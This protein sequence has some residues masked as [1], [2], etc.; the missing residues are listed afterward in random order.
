MGIGKDSSLH[1][2]SGCK[3]AKMHDASQFSKTVH[4]GAES[5]VES[6]KGSQIMI[7]KHENAIIALSQT[8]KNMEQQIK[9]MARIM[10][11]Q[12]I[13]KLNEN[14]KTG[15]EELRR[16]MHHDVQMKLNDLRSNM[17]KELADLASR[18]NNIVKRID[19]VEDKMTNRLH[20]R[21]D[22][23]QRQRTE[24]DEKVDKVEADLKTQTQQLTAQIVKSQAT[25]D[26][27]CN[28]IKKLFRELEESNEET[29]KQQ[30]NMLLHLETEARKH[31]ELS[32]EQ[33]AD[34]GVRLQKAVSRAVTNFEDKM[35]ELK[36]A[37]ESEERNRTDM[38][39][40]VLNQTVDKLNATKK[41]VERA[42]SM[43]ES[44][45]EGKVRGCIVGIGDL[46]KAIEAEKAQREAGD[47]EL[48]RAL[49]QEKHERDIDDD[50][51][52]GMIQNCMSTLSKMHRT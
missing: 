37:L 46:K 41:D 15:L 43:H 3:S 50:K 6:H 29:N 26:I 10:Q 16:E 48:V 27:K 13:S 34:E 36:A 19:E 14:M 31:Q 49:N 33:F 17:E 21:F 4:C 8:V 38:C 30:D 12:D 39:K 5:F 24:A 25:T 1:D 40:A 2:L 45:F 23:I 22:E 47:L 20:A 42:F 32:R 9:G 51:L 11:T 35:R 18:R 28:E 7:D 44:D 52:L